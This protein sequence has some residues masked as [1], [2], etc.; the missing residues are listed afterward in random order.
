MRFVVDGQPRDVTP[1]PD[2][3]A[4]GPYTFCLERDGRSRVFHCVQDGD[5]V[6]LFWEGRAY[7]L[8]LE[9]EGAR[10]RHAHAAGGLEA[11]MPGRVIKVNV[12]PGDAVKRGQELVV[13]EAMKMENPIRAPHDGRVIRL[14]ARV[15]DMV[16]PGTSLLEIE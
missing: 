12:A 9:K 11:P 3:R 5:V 16:G 14:E 15:G 13:V 1:D 7:Q 10:A 2:V 8:R 6:H 4:R